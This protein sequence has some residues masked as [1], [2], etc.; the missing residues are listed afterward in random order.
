MDTEQLE[1]ETTETETERMEK[2]FDE[3]KSIRDEVRVTVRGIQVRFA[4][5][6]KSIVLRVYDKT[7]AELVAILLPR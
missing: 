1:T 5:R 7:G 6:D 3:W 4:K 2:V